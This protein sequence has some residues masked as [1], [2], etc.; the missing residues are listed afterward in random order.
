MDRTRLDELIRR[1]A[2]DGFAV[3]PAVFDGRCLQPLTDMIERIQAATGELPPHLRNMRVMERNGHDAF[4]IGELPAFDPRFA[5]WLIRPE[6]VEPARRLLQW[7]NIRFH[8]C[9]LT[10]K[11]PGSGRA[12][13]WHR[14]YPNRYICPPDA[15][16][17]RVM[18]CLDGMDE[19]NGATRFISGSHHLGDEQAVVSNARDE[20]RDATSAAAACCPPGSL[21]FIHP[22]VIHGGPANSSTRPRRNLIVQWGCGAQLSGTEILSGLNVSGIRDWIA[23]RL[24]DCGSS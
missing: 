23:G 7:Q 2:Q 18:L 8:L 14:D 6:L 19:E 3:L 12:I 15:S 20:A 24:G 22:K 5:E 13:G 10:I 16:F 17:L 21:V 9:N 4:I 1:Y 11:H